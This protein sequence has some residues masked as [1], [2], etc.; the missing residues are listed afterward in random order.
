[1]R[2][3]ALAIDSIGRIVVA[4]SAYNGIESNDFALA[5]YNT[6]GSL[7]T[8]FNSSLLCIPNSICNG[9]LATNFNGGEDV[10]YGIVLQADGKIVVA[11]Y[12]DTN[13]NLVLARYTTHGTLDTTF[14]GGDGL[15]TT[16]SLR[17]AFALAID[18]DGRIVA[19]GEASNSTDSDFALA[20]YNTNGTLDTTFGG[21]D[22]LITTGFF[23]GE[24]DS[25][26][27]LAIDSIGRIVVAGYAY[28]SGTNS[29]FALAR[30]NTNGTLDMNFGGGGKVT[31]G[32]FSGENDSAFALAIDSDGRIVAAGYT[33]TGP[34]YGIALARYLP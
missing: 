9:K 13:L 1:D 6:D 29:D 22:G 25:A 7:D 15:V 10:A 24:D 14:G 17:S 19:A 33:D 12:G 26:S 2:A 8:S 11:G 21:G 20:R 18:S 30:Y 4:G 16:G 28:V 31:T 32:F 5:R 34:G 3:S 27:A 23:S